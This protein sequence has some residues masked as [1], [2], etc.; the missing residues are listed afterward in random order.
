MQTGYG[1][2]LL[3]GV[4]IG[5]AILLDDVITPKR[6]GPPPRV[7]MFHHGDGFD[8]PKAVSRSGDH[9]VWVI[10][11]DDTVEAEIHKEIR[12]ELASEEDAADEEQLMISVSVDADDE[13]ASDLPAAIGAVIDTARAE[14][15]DPTKAEIEAAV[16]AIAGDAKSI[17]V[18]VLSTKD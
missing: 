8:D 10:N 11:G 5:G 3:L 12:V 16:S 17:D 2:A 18:E 6:K 4:L 15:R 13:P 14:G 7:A 9:N 1:P